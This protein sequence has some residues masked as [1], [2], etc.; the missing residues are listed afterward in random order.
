MPCV[1]FSPRLVLTVVIFVV[2]F[3][4]VM[5]G[6]ISLISFSMYLLLEYG[7]AADLCVLILYLAE[8]VYQI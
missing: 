5:N 4:V 3:E 2:V 8:C 7:K 1:R 6:T